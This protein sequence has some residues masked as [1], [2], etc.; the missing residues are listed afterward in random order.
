MPIKLNNEIGTIWENP[1]CSS[2]RFCRPIKFIFKKEST[3]LIETEVRAIQNQIDNLCPKRLVIEGK[4]L[5]IKYILLLTMIDGTICNV[6]TNTSSS[7]KCYMVVQRQ[8]T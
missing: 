1:S 4:S 3:E 8:E 5:E 6:V 7:Q 2:T